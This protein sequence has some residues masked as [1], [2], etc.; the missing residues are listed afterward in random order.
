MRDEWRYLALRKS[1]GDDSFR[2]AQ[3]GHLLEVEKALECC[4][5]GKTTGVTGQQQGGGEHGQTKFERLTG[6]L[7]ITTWRIRVKA[8]MACPFDTYVDGLESTFICYFF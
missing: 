7:Q 1:G 5:T 4:P 3:E 8:V 6:T 2:R